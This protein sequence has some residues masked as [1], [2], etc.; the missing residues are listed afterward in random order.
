[1]ARGDTIAQT[2][3]TGNSTG[4]HLHL[5]V[6]KDGV[7]LNPIYFAETGDDGSSY[8]PPGTPGGYAIPDY[9]GEPMPDALYAAMLTEAQKHLG[10]PY[11]WG[12]AGP[13]SFD[14]SG[15]VSYVLSQSGVVSFGRLG[16]Q[17][18]FNQCTPVTK[19]NARPGD[20][21][22][23]TGTYSSPSPVS[24]VGIY[25]GNEQM[26]HCGNPVQY[27]S[28]NTTYWTNHFYAFGRL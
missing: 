19:K 7:Y 25:I 24:H 3:N 18:L 22:F 6:I 11:V 21:I 12:T 10:K 16:A 17:G 15:Y 5:E 23:F 13:D 20:L 1:V 28:I 4:P 27:A 9:P 2:G 14:C 26:I 8:I